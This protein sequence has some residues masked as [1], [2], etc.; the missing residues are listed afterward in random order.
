MGQRRSGVRIWVAGSNLIH[1]FT[2]VQSRRSG[3]S[4]YDLAVDPPPDLIVEIDISGSSIDKLAIFAQLKVPE[5]WRSDGERLEIRILLGDEYA[6]QQESHV[7][8]GIM[9][10]LV[11]KFLYSARPSPRPEWLRQLRRC[12]REKQD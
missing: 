10:A 7:L 11:T 8:A 1:A 6:E 5:V 2:S 12:A 3:G 9:A 4:A